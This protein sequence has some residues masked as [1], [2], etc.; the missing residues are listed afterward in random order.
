[1]LEWEQQVIAVLR[2]YNEQE[3]LMFETIHSGGAY[4]LPLDPTAFVPWSQARLAAK[5]EKLRRITA[6]AYGKA[7]TASLVSENLE[8]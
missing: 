2:P 4:S 1:V 7:G 3:R 8:E 5:L 6:R